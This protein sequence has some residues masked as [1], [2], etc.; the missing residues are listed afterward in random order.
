[1]G[2]I[3]AMSLSLWGLAL[4]AAFYY[5]ILRE[6]KRKDREEEPFDGVPD[7]EGLA[8]NAPGFRYAP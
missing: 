1:M 3:V 2:A 7:V 8:H 5:I 6:N 4:T